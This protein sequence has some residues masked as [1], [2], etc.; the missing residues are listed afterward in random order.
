MDDTQCVC[1]NKFQSLR[2]NI[3]PF[4]WMSLPQ[5]TGQRRKSKQEVFCFYKYLT[6]AVKCL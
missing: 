2:G 5:H 1:E 6:G 4:P 3:S